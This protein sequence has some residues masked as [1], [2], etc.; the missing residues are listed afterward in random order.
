[1]TQ[2]SALAPSST[3]TNGISRPS[4]RQPVDASMSPAK[5]EEPKEATVEPLALFLQSA[6]TV[7][8]PGQESEVHVALRSRD[9]QA[10]GRKIRSAAEETGLFCS[11]VENFDL[12]EFMGYRVSVGSLPREILPGFCNISI[13]MCPSVFSLSLSL[14]LSLYLSISTLPSPWPPFGPHT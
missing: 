9:Y 6:A 14:S 1:M 3:N 10:L 12:G 8:K 11:S 5:Q 7:L 13:D 2:H 4:D